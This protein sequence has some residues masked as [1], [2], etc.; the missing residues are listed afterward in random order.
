M[1]D[2]DWNK[3]PEK[4]KASFTNKLYKEADKLKKVDFTRPA[5]TSLSTKIKFYMVRMLQTGL[6]KQNPEYRDYNYWK[7]NGWIDNIRPWRKK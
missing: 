7:K 4:R 2:I 3:I 5:R 1:S 6:G